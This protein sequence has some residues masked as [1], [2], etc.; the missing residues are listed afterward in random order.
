M[1]DQ[2]TLVAQVAAI[3]AARGYSARVVNG[4]TGN[5]ARDVEPRP[6]YGIEV[7]LDEGHRVVWSVDT[8][9]RWGYVLLAVVDGGYQIAGQARVDF[10][11]EAEVDRVAIVIANFPYDGELTD[12]EVRT[13]VTRLLMEVEG[14]T[15][16]ERAAILAQSVGDE[17]ERGTNSWKAL[18]ET[19]L[20]WAINRRLFHPDGFS[21]N[22]R[23]EDGEPIGWVIIGDGGAPIRMDPLADLDGHR[24]FESFITSLVE[25]IEEA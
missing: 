25:V 11:E 17:E 6:T 9:G 3:L 13:E 15:E 10:G 8:E 19:G 18:Q 16:T 22:L 4:S 20:L 14:M 21:L 23:Y 2:H 7:G 5:S 12:E 24:R 1:A